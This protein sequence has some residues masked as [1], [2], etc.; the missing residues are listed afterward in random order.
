MKVVISF[1]FVMAASSF[2]SCFSAPFDFKFPKS[3]QPEKGWFGNVV[4]ESVN[5]Q[6]PACS[7]TS[8][9]TT[10][11][12]PDGSKTRKTVATMTCDTPEELARLVK[13]YNAL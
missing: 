5:Q 8:T 2:G 12:N 3:N 13:I 6:K 7:V 11:T 10:T 1:I 9:S 4:S